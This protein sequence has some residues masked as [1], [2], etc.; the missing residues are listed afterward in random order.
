MKRIL[1]VD[2]STIVRNTLKTTLGGSYEISEAADGQLG[3]DE[4]KKNNVDL[5]VIDVNMPNMDGITLTG[6]LRKLPQYQK[7]PIIMLTTESR[8]DKREQ[9]KAAGANG[10]MV[11]PCD[12]DKLLGVVGKLI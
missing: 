12:G 5:F 2:D 10:W 7:T 8:A 4:A 6:E 11:K 9:G 1:L 3:L